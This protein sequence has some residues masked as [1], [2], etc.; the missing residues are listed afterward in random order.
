MKVS[1]LAYEY[2]PIYI[3]GLGVHIRHISEA[4]SKKCDLN[5]VIPFKLNVPGINTVT[6]PVKDSEK[7][8]K[9]GYEM[10]KVKL[11]NEILP[12]N[13]E[14]FRSDIVHSHDWVTAKAGM[15]IKKRF[16]VPFVLTVHNTILGKRKFAKVFIK[17]KYELEKSLSE[18]DRIIAVSKHIKKDLVEFYGIDPKVVRVV[19]NG[20]DASKFRKGKEKDYVFFIGRIDPMKGVSYL[21]DAFSKVHNSFP[22][23]K[24]LICGEGREKYVKPIKERC[25]KLGLDDSV[26]FKGRV[27]QK[28]VEDLYANCTIVCLPSVYEPFGLTVLEGA[29]SGKPVITTSISGASEIVKNWENAVVVKPRDSAGLATAMEKLLGD[30]A[31]RDKM[32]RSA[33]RLARSFGW[34]SIAKETVKVY[35]ELV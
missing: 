35:K 20:V 22:Q 29:A 3:G 27:P 19:Y 30:K 13:F 16:G 12:D 7:C 24:L 14:S 8:V 11:Y 15:M 23:Y 6:V 25:S 31:L 4:L 32:S 10:D 33:T 17:E 9:A 2:F 26:I 18:A 21:L 28:E 5:I 34:D 1:I